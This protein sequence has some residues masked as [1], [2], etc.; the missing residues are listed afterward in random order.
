M[1][2]VNLSVGVPEY[3]QRPPILLYGDTPILHRMLE[4]P[5]QHDLHAADPPRAS[6]LAAPGELSPAG[7]W[8][9]GAHTFVGTALEIEAVRRSWVV[10]LAG[11]MPHTYRE[12][13]S[14]FVVRVF[15][16]LDAPPQNWPAIEEM[17]ASVTDGLRDGSPPEQLFVM[18]QHGM[19][20]SGLVAALVLRS[21]GLS[22]AEAVARI[23]TARPG[24]LSNEAFRELVL[25][26]R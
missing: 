26:D 5:P 10:D 6:L 24:A 21:L 2:R 12:A 3:R 9:G 16:D 25:G 19:N 18:C 1:A 17:I 11:D 8:M 23:V 20:R 13:A 15:P 4:N 7:I 22:G 14:R